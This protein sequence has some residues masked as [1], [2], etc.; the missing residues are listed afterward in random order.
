V[1]R[2]D[3]LQGAAEELH[4]YTVKNTFGCRK[5]GAPP[6]DKTKKP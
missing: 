6:P 4:A 1:G 3:V 5:F 2:F